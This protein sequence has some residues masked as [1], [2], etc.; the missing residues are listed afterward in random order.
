MDNNVGPYERA[1]LAKLEEARLRD[2]EDRWAAEQLHK[3]TDAQRKALY[4]A[5]H[6]YYHGDDE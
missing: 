6:E 2:E 4:R 3:Y 5:I 1:A